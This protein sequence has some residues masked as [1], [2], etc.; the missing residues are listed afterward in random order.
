M[1]Y[2][3][4]Q[5]TSYDATRLPDRPDLPLTVSHSTSKKKNKK[6]SNFPAGERTLYIRVLDKDILDTDGIGNGK[7]KFDNLIKGRTE[8]HE[9]ALYAHALDFTSNGYVTIDVTLL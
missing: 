3:D 6:N 4:H 9:V 5:K 8:R 7:F 1:D 2:M